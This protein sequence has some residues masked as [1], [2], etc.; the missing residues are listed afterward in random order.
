ML[1]SLLPPGVALTPRTALR[2]PPPHH[3]AP[4]RHTLLGIRDARQS[5]IYPKVD[6]TFNALSEGPTLS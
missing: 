2:R 6:P 5:V 1:A 4:F 3:H